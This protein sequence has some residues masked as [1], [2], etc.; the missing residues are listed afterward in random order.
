MA[1]VALLATFVCLKL[2]CFWPPSRCLVTFP[3]SCLCYW[4]FFI[5]CAAQPLPTRC[6]IHSAPRAV[7]LPT[8]YHTYCLSLHMLCPR[9]CRVL[10]IPPYLMHRSLACPACSSFPHVMCCS[11]ACPLRHFVSS[12]VVPLSCLP[13]VLLVAS[14]CAAH[15]A[16]G[17]RSLWAAHLLVQC[18]VVPLFH[19]YWSSHPGPRAST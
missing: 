1:T 8:I 10:L 5:A 14:L 15:P 2:S 12:F 19:G 17:P 11:P 18:A 13:I 7:R 4:L 6:A 3:V 16:L 9:L